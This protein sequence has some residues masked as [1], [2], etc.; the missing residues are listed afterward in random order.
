MLKTPA[1]TK[2]GKKKKFVGKEF[3]G[4]GTFGFGDPGEISL[5]THLSSTRNFKSGS[6]EER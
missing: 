1:A 6:S 3:V 5:W 2:Y 4:F